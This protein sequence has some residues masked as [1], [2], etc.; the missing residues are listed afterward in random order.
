MRTTSAT[1]FLFRRKELYVDQRNMENDRIGFSLVQ[2]Y[3]AL[4]RTL[5]VDNGPFGSLADQV[6]L[7]ITYNVHRNRKDRRILLRDHS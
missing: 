2:S 5:S 6:V 3:I 7:G 4:H 1:A